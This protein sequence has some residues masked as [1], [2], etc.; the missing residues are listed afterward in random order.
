MHYD[1]TSGVTRGILL[2]DYLKAVLRGADLPAD[3]REQASGSTLFAQYCPGPP[4]WTCRPE[5][6]PGSDL[7]F[8][9]EPT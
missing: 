6:L 4:G 5:D 3:L 8:A 7:T 1:A 9:F 2:S